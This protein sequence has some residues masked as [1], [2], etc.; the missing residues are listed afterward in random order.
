MGVQKRGF[1][2]G[3]IKAYDQNTYIEGGGP[4]SKGICYEQCNYLE[5]KGIW[6]ENKDYADAKQKAADFGEGKTMAN[7][8][9]AQRLRRGK[10]K[11]GF[12]PRAKYNIAAPDSYNT[13]WRLRACVYDPLKLNHELLCITGPDKNAALIF[14]PNT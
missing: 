7:Y 4:N 1:P 11:N 10:F 9:K 14:D 5:D 3:V 6:S 12:V 8:A 2:A 13:L